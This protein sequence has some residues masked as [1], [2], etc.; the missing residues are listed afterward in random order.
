MWTYSGDPSASTVDEVHF[1]VGD[2]DPADPLVQDEEIAY[3]LALFPKGDGQ[4]AW[5][6]AAAVAEAIAAKFAR[7]MDRSVGA[8]Q[9]SAKQQRDH[10][11]E[12]A[13][14][15]R[16]S[17]ATKGKGSTGTFAGIIP[18]APRLG[19]GGQKVLSSTDTLSEGGPEYY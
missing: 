13:S 8:L 16:L 7:K 4:P 3:H 15:L 6:A 9:Q 14:Q 19:G 11:V 12:L 5:L 17:W 1:L 18:G 2:T 10:Y